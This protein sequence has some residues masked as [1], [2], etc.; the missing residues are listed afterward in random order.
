MMSCAKT[1]ERYEK[2]VVFIHEPQTRAVRDWTAHSSRRVRYR[3]FMLTLSQSNADSCVHR[4]VLWSRDVK[5]L[6]NLR[7]PTVAKLKRRDLKP[8]LFIINRPVKHIDL[9]V[10][11]VVNTSLTRTATR[12]PQKDTTSTTFLPAVKRAKS[13]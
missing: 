3:S 12:N 8:F 10:V 13:S 5:N 7:S 6:V 11:R 2:I 4:S 9:T 1:V